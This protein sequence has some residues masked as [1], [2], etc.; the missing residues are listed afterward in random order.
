MYVPVKFNFLHGEKHSCTIVIRVFPIWI[1]Q[2][3]YLTKSNNSDKTSYKQE[4]Y[5]SLINPFFIAFKEVNIGGQRNKG[6]FTLNVCIA[7]KV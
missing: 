3:D 5:D 6:L 4:N 1:F 2:L 7:V